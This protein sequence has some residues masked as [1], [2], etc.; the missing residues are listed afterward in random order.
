MLV[1]FPIGL[2]VFSLVS[3]FIFVTGV[4]GP[5]WSTI[6]AYTMAGGL[7]GALLAA[8]PGLIDLLSIRDPQ[9]KKV[10][11]THM[12]LNLIVV[13]LYAINL[14]LRLATGSGTGL[15]M[16]L[17]IVAVLM[18]GISGWLGGELVYRHG[19]AVGGRRPAPSVQADGTR[20]GFADA[21]RR[22]PADTIPAGVEPFHH[23]ETPGTRRA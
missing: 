14:W 17:S 13:V 9:V 23:S 10:G 3:D 21:S 16:V 4:G 15:P 11:L 2:W 20:T 5:V 19:V 6:A 22:L 7:V 8:I 12:T 1:V 18:L